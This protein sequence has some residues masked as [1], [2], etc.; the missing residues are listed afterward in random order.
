MHNVHVW[1]FI[2]WDVL[3]PVNVHAH[4]G[5]VHVRVWCVLYSVNLHVHLGTVH[6]HVWLVVYCIQFNVN[7]IFHVGGVL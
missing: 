1:Y 4:L 7:G 6:V 5:T 3:Y 2:R